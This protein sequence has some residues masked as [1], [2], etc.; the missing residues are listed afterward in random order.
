MAPPGAT[1][2][3]KAPFP[4]NPNQGASGARL[5]ARSAAM[6]DQPQGR[7]LDGGSHVG[8]RA[9]AAAAR[10]GGGGRQLR[11]RHPGRWT[12]PVI[13][14]RYPPGQGR[15]PLGGRCLLLSCY[16]LRLGIKRGAY[17]SKRRLRQHRRRYPRR[18]PRHVSCTCLG[19]GGT[20]LSSPMR[21]NPLRPAQ[22]DATPKDSAAYDEPLFN[23]SG[24]WPAATTQHMQP[25]HCAT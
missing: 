4:G 23:P 5:Y 20:R 10:L 19:S 1:S 17:A 14:A 13:R 8:G 15:W 16:L 9:P 24:H 2:T 3:S 25:L 6:L 18:G 11:P 21:P 22:D 12:R 7:G